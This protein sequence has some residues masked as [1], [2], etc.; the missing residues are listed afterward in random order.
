[1]T[2]IKTR[3]KPDEPIF[4]KDIIAL[5]EGTARSTIYYQL[6]QAIKAGELSKNARGV[7]YLP[8]VSIVGKSVLPSLSPLIKSYIS[9]GD[10]VEGYWG[11]LML[12]NQEGLTTQNPSVLEIVTNKATKRLTR[13][14]AYGGYKDVILRPPK[15]KVTA[16]NV[17]VLK[18]LDLITGV[19]DIKD[20]QI[21]EKLASKAKLLNREKVISLAIYYPA[22]TSKRL[23]ESGMLNVFA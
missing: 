22:K 23:L 19:S 14:G 21:K 10:N 3:Y 6:D 18:F 7:Y 16:E 9:N 20:V 15:L 12:E 8:S 4:I 1:M 11:G 13:L 2:E 17:D 5:S